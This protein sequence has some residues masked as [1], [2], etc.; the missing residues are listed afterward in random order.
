MSCIFRKFEAQVSGR[1]RRRA[2]AA[3]HHR[4]ELAQ[5]F[6]PRHPAVSRDNIGSISGGEFTGAGPRRSGNGDT[7][8]NQQKQS[9]G[10]FNRYQTVDLFHTKKA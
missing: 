1:A 4:R 8:R 5:V 7:I 10:K 3:R 6:V 9:S 2:H